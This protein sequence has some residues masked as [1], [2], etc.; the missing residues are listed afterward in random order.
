MR[1]PIDNTLDAERFEKDPQVQGDDKPGVP[2]NPSVIQ[3]ND[4]HV[5]QRQNSARRET[6][7]TQTGCYERQQGA[8]QSERI[9]GASHTLPVC[10]RSS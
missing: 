9:T 5:E 6:S 4:E 2:A 3:P 7:I 8:V 1:A 10:E